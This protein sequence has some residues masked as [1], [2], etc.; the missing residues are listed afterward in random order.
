MLEGSLDTH[1]KAYPLKRIVCKVVE[2]LIAEVLTLR[3]ERK[4]GV[5]VIAE[6]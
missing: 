2:S 4:R 6:V 3:K 1:H 5:D